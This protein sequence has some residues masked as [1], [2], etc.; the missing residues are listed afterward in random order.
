MVSREQHLSLLVALDH[1]LGK[2]ISRPLI[3]ITSAELFGVNLTPAGDQHQRDLVFIGQ[4]N[5]RIHTVE[6]HGPHTQQ[7]A[8]TLLQ[9]RLQALL[10]H[11]VHSPDNLC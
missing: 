4:R 11:T 2:S 1:V 10:D 9:K 6:A 8:A 5:G 3:D 7:R